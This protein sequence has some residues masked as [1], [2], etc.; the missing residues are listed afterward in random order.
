MNSPLAPKESPANSRSPREQ[1]GGDP[2]NRGNR[3]YVSVSAPGR[4][5]LW[6]A[7][8][9]CRWSPAS[10]VGPRLGLAIFR[11]ETAPCPIFWV[12]DG[13]WVGLRRPFPTRVHPLRLAAPK[14]NSWV[15]AGRSIAR[16]MSW[17]PPMVAH[18]RPSEG[19][20]GE[21]GRRG[22]APSVRET[23]ARRDRS[24]AHRTGGAARGRPPHKGARSRALA[25][26]AG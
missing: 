3:P 15:P 7:G 26:P 10:G 13:F 25:K 20:R 16:N 6:L 19:T 24:G 17:G 9:A 4:N 23:R 14:S 18:T 8:H 2:L 12:R 1:A 22:A 11:R 5:C 21:A